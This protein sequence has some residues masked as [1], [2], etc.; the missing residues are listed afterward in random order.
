[1]SEDASWRR[2]S[3]FAEDSRQ[4]LNDQSVFWYRESSEDVI[5]QNPGVLLLYLILISV[6]IGSAVK[7]DVWVGLIPLA[8]HLI[9][10]IGNSLAMNSGFRFILPVDISHLFLHTLNQHL[11]QTLPPDVDPASRA[12]DELQS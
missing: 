8:F 5:R 6:G 12:R 4:W 1:M 10:A 11:D 7:R 3:R 2:F 9:Y